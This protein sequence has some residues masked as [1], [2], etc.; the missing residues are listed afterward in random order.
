[1]DYFDYDSWETVL[2]G[3]SREFDVEAV[4][5]QSEENARQRLE[6]E[7][8]RIEQQLDRREAIHDET[9]ADIESKLD[10]YLD[11]LETLYKQARSKNERRD[12]LKQRIREFYRELRKERRSRWRDR[13]DLER[14]RREVLHELEDIEAS[15]L[16][17]I[18]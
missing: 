3:Q 6:D 12:E 1:M 7:L 14:E 18:I 2:N 11:Q 5:E 4:L 8:G 9:V 13:Q 17:D 16:T 15:S 10:W